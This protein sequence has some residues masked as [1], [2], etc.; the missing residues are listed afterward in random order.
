MIDNKAV[1][2]TLAAIAM[3]LPAPIS[4]QS[5]VSDLRG[6]RGSSGEM[7][8]Q[9]RGYTMAKF[10]GGAQYWWN[11]DRDRCVRIVVRNGRYDS[12]TS[13]SAGDCGKGG[14]SAGA[15]VAGI[16]AIGLIAALASHKKNGGAEH[17]SARHDDEYGRGYRDGLYSGNYDRNDSDAY[18]EGFMAGEAERNNRSA[19]NSRF[20]QDAPDAAQ[21]ACARRG[22]Q[23]LGVPPGSAVPISVYQYGRGMYEITVASG[24]YKARCDT[25]AR[26][27]IQQISPY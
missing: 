11:E 17:G 20:V 3:A 24:H 13:A 8:M 1:P 18:H 12:V 27:N 15:A 23:F 16:A 7:E 9:Q 22:D 25:D 14:V 26:G 10:S 5:D 4:A 6:A 2:L 19:A 21:A